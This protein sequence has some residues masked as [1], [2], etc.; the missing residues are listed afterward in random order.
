MSLI[1]CKKN[2]NRLATRKIRELILRFECV[3]EKNF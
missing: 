3:Q 2:L 1:T